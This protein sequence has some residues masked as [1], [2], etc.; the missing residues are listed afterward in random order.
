MQILAFIHSGLSEPCSFSHG[1]SIVAKTDFN[2]SYSA[3]AKQ[4]A[5]TNWTARTWLQNS[6]EKTRS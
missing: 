6:W 5:G 1:S 3:S 4:D 2:S